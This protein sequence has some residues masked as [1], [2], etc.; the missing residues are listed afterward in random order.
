MIKGVLP[1]TAAL[2]AIVFLG[3]AAYGLGVYIEA[4]Q[5]RLSKDPIYPPEGIKFTALPSRF[6]GWARAGV[7]HQIEGE[8][9]RTL[10]TDNYLTRTFERT[11]NPDGPDGFSLHLAYYTGTIDT[12]PHVPERCM[13]GA[14]WRIVG[15]PR[16]VDVPITFRDAGG[17]V[18]IRDPDVDRE[19]GDVW[20]MRDPVSGR[21]VRMPL[22]L[23]KLKLN[24]THFENETGTQRQFAGYFFIAN[25]A[26][27][28]TAN[29][30]RVNAYSLSNRYAYYAKVQFTSNDVESAEELGALAG[31]FLD[32]SFHSIMRLLPDWVEVEAGRYPPEASAAAP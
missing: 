22:G 31:A 19:Y 26:I 21:R 1:M 14:G 29:Q 25:G 8:E 24:V 6:E 12:V 9:L 16:V 27:Y 30:V 5:I 11:D 7:D 4:E 28:P 18:L 13:V 32:D 17:D 23:D 20:L 15:S 10:G 2:V 3:A